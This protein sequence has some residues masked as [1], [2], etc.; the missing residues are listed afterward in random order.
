MK[1]LILFTVLCFGFLVKAQ[2]SEKLR[3]GEKI[4]F[5]R[6]VLLN[7]D[8]K[9]TNIDLPN[10]KN[11][12]DRFVL[13]YFFSP[14]KSVKELI[15][16]NHD[17]ERILNKYQNNSCKGASDIEYVTICLEKDF[18]KWQTLLTETNYNKSKFTGKKTNYL[19]EDGLKDKTV[20]AFKVSKTPSLFLVNPKGRLY[21]ETDSFEVLEKTFQNICKVNAAYS[22]A[23]ISG[24]LLMG[25]KVKNPLTEHQVYLVKGNTDTI[26]KTSTDSY[27]DFVFKQVDTTQ[28][29][30]IR[31][32]QNAKTKGGP[33]V[34]LAK[35]NGEIVSEFK[36][37]SLGN[38]EY[39]LLAIDVEK[40]STLEEDDD[41]TMKYKKF[42]STTKKDLTVTENIYYES[43]KYAILTESEI[44]LDKV[45][46]ILNANPKVI[47]E[48]ISHTDAQ[49]DDASN[50][51]LS[52]NRSNAVIDYIVGKGISKSRLKALGKGELEIRNR[53]A[54]GVSCS[55]KEHEY[56]RRTEFK[57]IKN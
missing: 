2:K 39:K 11:T 38:F 14:D 55:D 22:T 52:E 7:Q 47:L 44:V 1:R 37:N 56:N 32:E 26:K 33:K 13:V 51:K 24:K 57:F 6:I 16:F 40:L 31:I 45:L 3:V 19:A 21:L 25:E 46:V 9:P 27:G 28:N 8:N 18:S 34:Y 20:S 23:D 15:A 36:K 41:I 17:V 54:N 53:C 12:T 10:G 4:P 29:L 50:L 35:Q 30:S 49:G 48:V 5:S 42:N 43:A